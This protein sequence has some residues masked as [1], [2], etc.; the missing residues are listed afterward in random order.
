MTDIQK[1]VGSSRTMISG[2]WQIARAQ[3]PLPLPVADCSEIT[4][5]KFKRMHHFHCVMYFFPVFFRKDSSVPYMGTAMEMVHALNL[6][7]VISLQSA[8]GRGSESR[9]RAVCGKRR[10]RSEH[11]WISVA[12]LELLSILKIVL[13][14]IMQRLSLR[15]R[16]AQNFELCDLCAT[17]E[18]CGTPEEDLLNIS[19]ISAEITTGGIMLRSGWLSG[20]RA[21]KPQVF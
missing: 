12:K 5:F 19:V 4:V 13:E 21:G 14:R 8:T 7:T 11:L 3:D 9:L 2:S 20:G 6:K 15:E 10:S 16:I 18:K 1:D 17:G